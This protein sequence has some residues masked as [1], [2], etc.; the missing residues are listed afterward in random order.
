MRNESAVRRRARAFAI[1]SE[2]VMKVTYDR[3]MDI[4][5]I[6]LSDSVIE[7]SDEEAPGVIVDYDD[8]GG[9][10]GLE[11]LDASTSVDEPQMIEYSI[12]E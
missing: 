7:E 10:A 5:R 1:F 9:I 2:N 12:I 11:I 6:I 4:L 3:K 8:K